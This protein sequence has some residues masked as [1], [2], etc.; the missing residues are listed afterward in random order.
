MSLRLVTLSA[1]PHAGRVADVD[2]QLAVVLIACIVFFTIF[3]WRPILR[4]RPI[5]WASLQPVVLLTLSSLLQVAFIVI[6]AANVIGLEN[7]LKF[8]VFGVPI[9]VFAIVLAERRKRT[10]SDP[11]RGTVFAPSSD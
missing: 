6:V 1:A 4:T 7:S 10:R 8:A 9:C 3:P 5:P 2:N 11:P